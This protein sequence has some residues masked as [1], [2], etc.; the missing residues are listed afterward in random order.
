MPPRKSRASRIIGERA[1]RSIAAS[2]SASAEASVPSTISS[3]IG[4]TRW[5]VT[6]PVVGSGVRDEDSGG[7]QAPRS[8]RIKPLPLGEAAR[9]AG[10]GLFQAGYLLD[11]CVALTPALSQR[12][13]EPI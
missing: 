5:P 12:E 10:E 11:S 6:W 8:G 1:V 3:T 7:I 4:S 13:R 9:S 2:T